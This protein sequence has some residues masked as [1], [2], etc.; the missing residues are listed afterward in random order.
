MLNMKKNVIGGSNLTA[1]NQNI[2]KCKSVYGIGIK[3]I[4]DAGL[5]NLESDYDLSITNVETL[6][7]NANELED[8]INSLSQALN[9]IQETIK[10]CDNINS[11]LKRKRTILKTEQDKAILSNDGV[12][13]VESNKELM[14][15]KDA[16]KEN[17][18]NIKELF[19]QLDTYNALYNK[20]LSQ[21]TSIEEKLQEYDAFVFNECLMNKDE[22]LN[23]LYELR[24]VEQQENIDVEQVAQA[25]QRCVGRLSEL[26]YEWVNPYIGRRKDVLLIEKEK[27][28]NQ[29]NNL[30]N[31]SSLLMN[32]V[33]NLRAKLAGATEKEQYAII[34][35][36]DSIEESNKEVSIALL[37][38]E[39]K[40]KAIEEVLNA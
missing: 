17:R 16:I 36:I 29:I 19:S 21:K 23:K 37:F 11:L 30:L 5:R 26:G 22:L 13:V 15:V 34:N 32:E 1:I 18:E 3:S 12:S 14:T 31:C 33:M 38:A 40:R 9:V 4:E 8:A 39:D 24:I 10:V 7:I 27:V 2:N 6:Q 20:L 35:R 25:K 28:S